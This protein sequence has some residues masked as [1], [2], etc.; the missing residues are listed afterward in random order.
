MWRRSRAYSSSGSSGPAPRF[1]VARKGTPYS[2]PARRSATASSSSGLKGLRT[3][4]SAPTRFAA[5]L[6]PPVEPVSRITGISRVAGSA[7]SSSQSSKPVVPGMFTSRTMT[8][9]RAER[10]RRRAAA[11]PSAS[12]TSTSATSNVVLNNVRRA[13]SSSTSKM[14][15]S[16]DLPGS[17]TWF[18]L[19]AA[20]PRVLSHVREDTRG[21]KNLQ[22]ATFYGFLRVFVEARAGFPAQAARRDVLPQQRTRGVAV[23]TEA[24]LEH[25]HDRDARV[26]ADQV[27]QG[28]RAERV[29]EAE[30]GDGV[31][32][33]RLGDAVVQR[34]HRLV[35]ERHQDPV[36]D[37]AR[38]VVCDGRRLAEVARELR[39]L[40]GGLVGGVAAADDLD[41]L[42]DRYGIEE[43]HA[44]HPVRPAGRGGK[45]PNRDRGRVGGEDRPRRQ[46]LVG[47]AEELF[48]RVRVLDDRL[49]HQVR[50]DEIVDD[51][52]AAHDLVGGRAPFLLQLP[53]ALAHCAE[54]P[55]GRTGLRVVKGHVPA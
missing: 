29:R 19:S 43:V 13:G 37:E 48:L 28:E 55:V 11:A 39:D 31:D 45:R 22:R 32:R 47:T 17:R 10:I 6:V 46:L 35:D 54:R 27:G 36:R 44:D 41:E 16:R 1:F 7:F 40:A 5:A 15:K 24:F 9:G 8:S 25:L 42:Q 49:D 38:E 50:G 20:T 23:V 2:P 52:D 21:A 26:E 12:V 34:P 30:L 53:E 51:G 3:N 14:R 18:V 4:A 33:L